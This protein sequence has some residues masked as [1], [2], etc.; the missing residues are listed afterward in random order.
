MALALTMAEL[1]AVCA[2][3]FALV[4]AQSASLTAA[5]NFINTHES[6]NGVN[7]ITKQ[8]DGTVSR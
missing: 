1:N 3:G 7:G 4:Q 5:R 2:D 6:E 8:T